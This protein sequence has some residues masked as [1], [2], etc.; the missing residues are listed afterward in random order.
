MLILDRKLGQSILIGNGITVTPE[1]I[2]GDRVRI[3]IE[4]PRDVLV[5]RGEL[6]RCPD[7]QETLIDCRCNG[8]EHETPD[9]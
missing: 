9:S 7:C 4:A 8:G 3:S 2:G 1:R 6:R 5:L